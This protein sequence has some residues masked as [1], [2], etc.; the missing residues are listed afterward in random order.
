MIASDFAMWCFFR[1][2]NANEPSK[3]MKSGYKCV[4]FVKNRAHICFFAKY[5]LSLGR[6]GESVADMT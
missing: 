4:I 2:F 3:W 1:E 6:Y 5:F